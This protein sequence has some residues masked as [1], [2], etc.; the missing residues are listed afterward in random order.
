MMPSGSIFGCDSFSIMSLLLIR[1]T[2]NWALY[3][4]TMNTILS[5]G[6]V[7]LCWLLSCFS[8]PGGVGKVRSNQLVPDPCWWTPDKDGS[9]GQARGGWGATRTQGKDGSDIGD[10]PSQ[11]THTDITTK[12]WT[13]SCLDQFAKIMEFFLLLNLTAETILHNVHSCLRYSVSKY[14][15]PKCI[16]FK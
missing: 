9:G 1:I 6:S 8:P 4:L 2:I 11:H 13:N 14:S 12:F 15:T 10:T 5:V 3:F 16:W 7:Q